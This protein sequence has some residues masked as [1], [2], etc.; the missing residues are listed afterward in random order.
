MLSLATCP[1]HGQRVL[2]RY[3]FNQMLKLAKLSSAASF[4]SR[5]TLV[6]C[7]GREV[8]LHILRPTENGVVQRNGEVEKTKRLFECG[9]AQQLAEV[10]CEA[11]E[12]EKERSGAERNPANRTIA[13]E[14]GG[15]DNL[16]IQI[17][18]NLQDLPRE[19]AVA[20]TVCDPVS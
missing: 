19:L 15:S 2:K 8:Q 3:N 10:S 16:T 5:V 6:H 7:W 1:K 20:R 12:I 17:T 18:K 13:K 4:G 14:R 11:E 9:R